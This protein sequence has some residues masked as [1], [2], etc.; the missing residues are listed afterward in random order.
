[1]PSQVTMSQEQVRQLLGKE[2]EPATSLGKRL[3]HQTGV[4]LSITLP[5]NLTNGN[6][7]RGFH[8]RA[9]NKRRQDYETMLRVLG[10]VRK[11]FEYPVRLVV[12]RILGPRQRL[13]DVSSILRGSWKELE[14][15]MVATGFFHDDSPEWIADILPRQDSSQRENGPAVMIEVLIFLAP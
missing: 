13:W 14:D 3:R 7:G 10:H 1:M 15:A 2:G 8:W 9:S 12:T 11:P 5:I 4:L 6:A